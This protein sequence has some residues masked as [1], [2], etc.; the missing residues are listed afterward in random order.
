MICWAMV[1][2]MVTSPSGSPATSPASNRALARVVEVVSAAAQHAA[3]AVERV[4]GAAAVPG[5][6][7]L[8][9][10]AHV[11]ERGQARRT[12]W[13]G[14]STRTAAGSWLFRAVA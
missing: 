1:Q 2:A 4:A 11:V 10:S 9:P 12:T 6:G 3:D 13:N 14:S 8:D 7:L 5:L